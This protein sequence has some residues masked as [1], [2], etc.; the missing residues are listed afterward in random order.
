MPSFEIIFGKTGD[1][2]IGNITGVTPNTNEC[3][4]L[5]NG[6]E[7]ALGVPV[8]RTRVDSIEDVAISQDIKTKE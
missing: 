8:A 5:T 1:V 4:D 2:E 7:R 3:L 6:Y